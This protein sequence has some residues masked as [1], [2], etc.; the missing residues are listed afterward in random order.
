MIYVVKKAPF[1]GHGALASRGDPS[2]TVGAAL[3]FL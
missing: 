2:R 1:P 3:A